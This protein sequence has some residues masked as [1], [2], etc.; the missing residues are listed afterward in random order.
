MLNLTPV[1]GYIVDEIRRL[2]AAEYTLGELAAVVGVSP[3]T[4]RNWR[5]CVVKPQQARTVLRRLRELR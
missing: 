1:Q 2:L 4:L 3:R 5:D